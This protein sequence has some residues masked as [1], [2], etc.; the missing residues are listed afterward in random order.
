MA[1]HG[2][3]PGPGACHS[4]LRPTSNVQSTGHATIQLPSS[5]DV[6]NGGFLYSLLAQVPTAHRRPKW[7]LHQRHSIT[8]MVQTFIPV[9]SDRE[10]RF[11]PVSKLKRSA[12][13]CLCRI[14]ITELARGQSARGLQWRPWLR[15]FETRSP[16]GPA[17][18]WPCQ[19]SPSSL[20]LWCGQQACRRCEAPRM[21]P[22][23]PSRKAP[24]RRQVGAV[25]AADA[26]PC[27]AQAALWRRRCVILT[28]SWRCPF[29]RSPR[30][31]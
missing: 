16:C 14:I 17:S 12:A 15:A 21:R 30:Y 22:P 6:T 28:W 2:A 27:S 24:P 19:R 7:A 29:C 20:N 31:W 5:H 1:R 25:E 8:W 23:P 18:S 10:S 13:K 9:S 3:R 11:T 4:P 26:Q